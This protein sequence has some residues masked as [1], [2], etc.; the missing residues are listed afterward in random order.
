GETIAD[1]YVILRL[2]GEGG[3]GLVYEAGHL[4]LRQTV[5]LKTLHFDALDDPLRVA[6]FE[7]EARSAAQL[8]SR[9]AVRVLD[10]DVTDDGVP[11]MVL[12]KLEGQDLGAVLKTQTRLP[13]SE[14]VDYVLQACAAIVEA[15]GLG[16]IH[17]DLKPSNLF[18]AEEEGGSII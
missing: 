1:K 3:M 10:V 8:R 18:L 17:R 2:L 16:I 5:A 15:H 7:R 6:R 9:H 11:Y 13:I 4:R 12:E 14:A